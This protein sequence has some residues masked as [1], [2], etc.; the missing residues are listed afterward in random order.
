MNEEKIRQWRADTPGSVQRIHLNNAG[1]A[2]MPKPVLEAI[3]A[4]LSLENQIGGYEAAA[5]QSDALSGFY[6][7]LASLLHAPVSGMAHATS[8]TDAYN[9]ALSSIPFSEGDVIL[10]TQ[11]DYVSNQIAFMEL[12]HRFGV[13]VKYCGIVPSGGMDL[14]DLEEK[15]KRFQPKLVAITHI[16]TNSGLVQDVEAAGAIIKESGAWYLVDACQSVGQMPL[17]VAKIGCDFL[18]GTFRKF[19]RGPRGVG[20][21]YVS[22]RALHAGLEPLFVDLHG[23]SWSADDVY[24]LREDAKRFEL[25]ERS[26]ALVAGAREACK[27]ANDIGLETIEERVVTLAAS[28]REKLSILPAVRVLDQGAKLSGIVTM[29]FSKKLD[30]N[31]LIAELRCHRVNA[32]VTFM[33]YARFDLARKDAAWIVRF[34]PHYYNTEAELDKAV[35]LVD[36]L[37]G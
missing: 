37:V 6:Q 15:I 17:D 3:R 24:Q 11:D 33:E 4:H 26:Y 14:N 2:L 18:T 7:E 13:E 35:A 31:W 27:Y 19:L 12:H 22:E 16:P 32:S 28:L 1:A 29:D 36:R 5:M 20:F 9:R 34:S 10:T 30:P 21:L 25:W 23:A 8:A